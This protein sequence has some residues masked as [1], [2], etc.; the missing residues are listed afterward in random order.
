M[1]LEA[2]WNQSLQKAQIL[3]SR[4]P[5]QNKE[6]AKESLGAF[7]DVEEKKPLIENMLK[8]SGTFTMA[9]K[10]VREKHFD[11]YFRLV[12]QN[13]FLE[14][15]SLYQ[16]VLQIAERLQH[17][18]SSYLESGAYKKALILADVLHQFRP[19]Q[20]QSNRLKEVSK[21]LLLLEYQVPHAMLL[22]A[23]KTQEQYQL[24]SHYALII[25]LEAMKTAFFN[26][27]IALIEA[28]EYAKVLN[29]IEPYTPLSICK[30]SIANIIKKLY[31]A[32]LNT[33]YRE[34][35]E[36]IDWEKTL[37]NYLQFFKAD[38]PLVE[39]AKTAQKM[40]VLQQMMMTLP[41]VENPRYATNILVKKKS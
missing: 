7:L 11:F 15:T 8:R 38:K 9:E 12:A 10:A 16:K 34:M 32:Q 28:K 36:S 22:E 35:N 17:E 20:N 4:E 2:L 31:I 33:A 14:A 5:L 41:P 21:A 30:Q 40:E 27:Q 37:Q 13:H 23:L 25:E 26:Q 18:I 24:Q 1:Q 6:A 19:Y 29:N 3:L 39:F